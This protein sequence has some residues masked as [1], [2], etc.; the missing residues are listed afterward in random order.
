MAASVKS[1]TFTCEHFVVL[2]LFHFL[3][4]SSEFTDFTLVLTSVVG[5]QNY[6]NILFMIILI[7]MYILKKYILLMGKNLL[8][9]S[10]DWFKLMNK[11]FNIK[12]NIILCK[13]PVL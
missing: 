2:S 9:F 4:T 6:T 8:E 12:G 11:I 1:S 7:Y 3:I 10:A 13:V 5:R